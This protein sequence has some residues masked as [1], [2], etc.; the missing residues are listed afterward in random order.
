MKISEYISGERIG[1]VA[2]VRWCPGMDCPQSGSV[3]YVKAEYVEN[4]F[5]ACNGCKGSIT[6]VTHNSD[7]VITQEMYD[8]RPKVIK[9]W[10]AQNCAA[11]GPVAVP[12]GLVNSHTIHGCMSIIERVRAT[13]VKKNTKQLAYL[14]CTKTTHAERPILY[15]LFAD[16]EWITAEGGAGVKDIPFEDYLFSMHKH[17]Y[18][19]SP[20]GAGPDCHRTWEAI[21]MGSIPIVKRSPEYAQFEG[22]PILF[23]DDWDEVTEDLLKK[24]KTPKKAWSDPRLSV[25]YYWKKIGRRA[26]KRRIISFS[27][28]GNDKKYNQGII[29]NVKL[30]KE[31]Y[32]GW[33]VRVYHGYNAPCVYTLR[34]MGVEMF[35]QYNVPGRGGQ[36]WRFLA[37]SS[38][39][40][41]YAIFRDSDSRLNVREKAAVEAWIASGKDA[42]SMHDHRH[43]TIYPIMAG[44]WGIKGGVIKDIHELLEECPNKVE[45][46]DDQRFLR[47]YI[48]PKI[49]NSMLK[50]SSV[51]LKWPYEPFPEHEDWD[52][53][54]VGEIIEIGGV[55]QAEDKP[56]ELR[57]VEQVV[58]DVPAERVI[59]R[60]DPAPVRAEVKMTCPRCH[61]KGKGEPKSIGFDAKGICEK[62]KG[63][64]I[65][66]GPAEVEAVRPA[67]DRPAN[68]VEVHKQETDMILQAV[69]TVISGR[70][71]DI[72]ANDGVKGST[73]NALAKHGWP[74]VM[75][76]PS[77]AA[78]LLLKKNM[79]TF[80]DVELLHA[81]VTVDGIGIAPFWEHD[82][83]RLSTTN[84]HRSETSPEKAGYRKYYITTVSLS[85]IQ[86]AFPGKFEFVNIDVEGENLALLHALPADAWGVK[87]ICIEHQGEEEKL[88]VDY[89]KTIGFR[90]AFRSFENL[91]LERED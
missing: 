74:G 19:F 49:E 1:A 16:K 67:D 75:V 6:L 55:R 80:P 3:V 15:N 2:D 64:G 23:V 17:K 24:T 5:R 30:A 25:K 89:A 83:H 31:I 59:H 10:L 70:F 90:C 43:H 54:H 62:C 35:A 68:V 44:M 84:E 34:K 12:I 72:G 88:F 7:R 39:D 33:E 18:T 61:G 53:E 36:F 21:A 26:P 48:W 41:E 28:F 71:L 52:G 65:Y 85:E 87:V 22:L 9:K 46:A 66:R 58:T 40:V 78:F 8:N 4:F 56:E 50:H 76:E 86:D 73:T 45:L 42:H 91:L 47:K 20:P 77:P 37:M 60:K 63:G 57:P 32:P 82:N 51:D 14:C 11:R 29:E 79:Q 13:R 27:V 38:P 69:E 81:A